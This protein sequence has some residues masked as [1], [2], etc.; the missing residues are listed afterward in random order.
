MSVR[1]ARFLTRRVKTFFLDILSVPWGNLKT[2]P[3]ITQF[4][5]F[6]NVIGTFLCKIMFLNYFIFWTRNFDASGIL[7]RGCNG[8]SVSGQMFR[9]LSQEG[10][11]G[12]F[13]WLEHR[14]STGRILV[15]PG[16]QNGRDIKASFREQFWLKKRAVCVVQGKT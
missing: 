16:F 4:D 13:K 1:V 8:L 2:D 14:R 3:K 5:L 6:S 10:G 15:L 12:E 11:T 7:E 9:L